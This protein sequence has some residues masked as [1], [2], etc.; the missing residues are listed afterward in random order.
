[1]ARES[2]R[3]YN[4][5]ID[6]DSFRI[7]LGDTLF[8]RRYFPRIAR[9]IEERYGIRVDRPEHLKPTRKLRKAA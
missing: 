2:H 6:F 4:A 5:A 7:M 9:L 1:M 3:A 8:G